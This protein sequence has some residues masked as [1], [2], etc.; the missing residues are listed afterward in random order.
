MNLLGDDADIP[1]KLSSYDDL[2]EEAKGDFVPSKKASADY[3]DFPPPEDNKGM[4]S[5]NNNNRK[6][7]KIQEVNLDT[8]HEARH[9]E[10][11]Q[12]GANVEDSQMPISPTKGAA[13]SILARLRLDK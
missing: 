8:P 12:P 2:E 5:G 9:I 7:L 13:L 3:E 4:N 6:P 11:E 1:D 10:D